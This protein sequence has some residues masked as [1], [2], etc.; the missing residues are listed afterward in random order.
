MKA[1]V[2]A[3]IRRIGAG[4]RPVA[5]FDRLLLGA[6]LAAFLATGASFLGRAA[7]LLEL[8]THFRFQMAAGALLLLVFA[9]GRRRLVAAAL[10]AVACAPN[11]ALLAPWVLSGPPVAEASAS[12]VRL[13]AANVSYRNVDYAAL[14]EQIREAD[15]DV[16]GLLEVDQAWLDGLSALEGEFDWTVFYPQ[17][18]A[19]GLAL[20]SKLPLREVASS[21]YVEGDQQTSIAVELEV[22]EMP[23]L[24]VL[25]HVSAPTTPARARL[26]NVQFA[27][28]AELLRTDA[29]KAGILLGDLNA[30][31]WSPYY[32][33][34]VTTA[35]LS[36]AARGYGYRATWPTGFNVLKIPIDHCLVSEGLRVESFRT[37]SNFGS[38]HLPIVVELTADFG[39]AA[40]GG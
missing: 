34:L 10:A 12:A 28:I 17:E 37:G 1:A 15:P 26:R 27:R 6:A 23:A 25:A 22:Q 7:W 29:G 2:V 16:V 21:P 11:A 14:L 18:G 35:G 3:G 20:Y 9:L 4:D 31:P 38:D 36:N 30:T 39:D 5:S 13:M 40:P 19:Y 24:L 33:E 8:T 32:R